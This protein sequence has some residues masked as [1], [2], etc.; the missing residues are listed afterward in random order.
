MSFF[1]DDSANEVPA[2]EEQPVV[3]DV[4]AENP[5]TTGGWLC[6]CG[7]E[8]VGDFCVSCGKPK[9]SAENPSTTG[10]WLCSCGQENVGDFCVSCGKP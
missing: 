4:D 5:S 1:D 7:Q 8:N 2:N 10:G 6:S 3:E 9:P